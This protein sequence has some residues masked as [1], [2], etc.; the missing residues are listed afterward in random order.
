MQQT[1]GVLHMEVI[2]LLLQ[3]NCLQA[4]FKYCSGFRVGQVQFNFGKS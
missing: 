4:N 2:S 1:V 3:I